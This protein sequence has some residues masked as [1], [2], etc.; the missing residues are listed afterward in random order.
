MGIRRPGHN[1]SPLPRNNRRAEQHSRKGAAE[2]CPESFR[3]LGAPFQ[4]LVCGKVSGYR[5]WF[6]VRWVA[7]RGSCRPW[8]EVGTGPEL[9]RGSGLMVWL[10]FLFLFFI[11][12]LFSLFFT[13]FTSLISILSFLPFVVLFFVSSSSSPSFFLLSSPLHRRHPRPLL[14]LIGKQLATLR[15]IFPR[16]SSSRCLTQ[17][18]CRRGRAGIF[19]RR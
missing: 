4:S 16:T 1:P 18:V 10:M 9:A 7:V 2:T 8:S 13:A 6:G 5:G 14:E 11:F 19:I 12:V 17:E 3:S 15:K